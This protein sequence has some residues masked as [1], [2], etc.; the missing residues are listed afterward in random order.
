MS[1]AKKIEAEPKAKGIPVKQVMFGHAIRMAGTSYLHL[2]TANKETAGLEMTY[3]AG[4]VRIE[5]KGEVFQV[6]MG[7]I[8]FFTQA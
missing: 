4:L 6:P 1:T 7:N 2:S 3:N 5:Y 8:A